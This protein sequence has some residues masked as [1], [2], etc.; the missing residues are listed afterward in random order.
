VEWTN[1]WNGFFTMLFGWYA[2]GQWP[3]AWVG[4]PDTGQ[5]VVF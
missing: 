1:G 3:C 2:E 5:L 4:P